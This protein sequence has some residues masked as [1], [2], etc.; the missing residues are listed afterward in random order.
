MMRP[1]SF[2]K[3][4]DGSTLEILYY[5]NL[6]YLWKHYHYTNSQVPLQN[7][8]TVRDL[9]LKN[10]HK[11]ATQIYSYIPFGT[12]FLRAEAPSLELH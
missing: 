5:S 9:S 3:C 7:G 2:I 11:Y 8:L 4:K 6:Y 1:C 10:A 12:S